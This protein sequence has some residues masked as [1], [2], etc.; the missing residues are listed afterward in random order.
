M[1]NKLLRTPLYA[2]LALVTYN[3]ESLRITRTQS[4]D[5]GSESSRLCGRSFG[6]IRLSGDALTRAQNSRASRTLR[7]PCGEC[8]IRD[9]YAASAAHRLTA[10]SVR[11]AESAVRIQPS[12]LTERCPDRLHGPAPPIGYRAGANLPCRHP[13]W[14]SQPRPD[15]PPSQVKNVPL[16]SASAGLN[17]VDGC[18]NPPVPRGSRMATAP[19]APSSC[20]PL[21]YW[22]IFN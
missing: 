11:P 14:P 21:T 9:H 5:G 15:R 17:G 19:V 6:T 3:G 10:R 13:F 4:S 7:W 18:P 8:Q 16:G 1:T 2:H 20:V 12:D 22:K